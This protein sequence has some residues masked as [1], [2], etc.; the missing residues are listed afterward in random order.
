MSPLISIVIPSYKRPEYL[1]AALL[2]VD[3]ARQAARIG[4]KKLEIIVI[5]DGHDASTHKICEVLGAKWS[6][7]V[8]YQRSLKGPCAGPAFC[9]NQGIHSALGKLIYLLDDDDVYLPN[10]FKKSINLFTK[11][12]FEVVLEPSRR[13]YVNDQNKPSYVTG[14][15]GHNSDAFRF[16]MTGGE[17]SHITPGATAFRKE[18]FIRAGSYDETLRFG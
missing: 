18:I 17:K 9:R 12:A 5:D 4:S 11:S 15:Y 1:K 14:P 3:D 2:S 8:R 6:I 16:L 10:R 7:K 13:S